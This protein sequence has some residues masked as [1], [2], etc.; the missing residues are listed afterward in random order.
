MKF[1]EGD[2]VVVVD[3]KRRERMF[4]LSRG[5]KFSLYSRQHP[6]ELLIGLEEGTKIELDGG[7]AWVF[8]PTMRQYV[9][10]VKRNAQPIYPKDLGLL[11]YYS[12]IRPGYKVLEIGLGVGALSIAILNAIGEQGMLVTYERREDFAKQGRKRVEGFLG[13]KN[14]FIVKVKDASEGIDESGFNAAFIDVPEPWNVIENVSNAV[15]AGA[16][17]LAFIPT[18]IQVKQYCDRLKELGKFSYIE[19]IET[20]LRPWDIGPRSLRPAHRMVAHTGFI[21]I[22]R[23]LADSPTQN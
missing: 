8:R 19:I 4:V 21:V 20:L 18:A 10:N 13:A 3:K 2:L 14:N 9:L 12:D 5:K 17:V 6:H 1:K 16:N 11:I 23:R 7:I 15:L 22:C